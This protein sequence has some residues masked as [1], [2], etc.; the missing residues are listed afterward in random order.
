[1]SWMNSGP[2]ESNCYPSLG[3]KFWLCMFMVSDRV[4]W[5]SRLLP[6]FQG[7]GLV[8]EVQDACLASGHQDSCLACGGME[9]LFSGCWPGF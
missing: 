2:V 6:G 8:S 3:L 5:G 9:G 4:F 1:M 7:V